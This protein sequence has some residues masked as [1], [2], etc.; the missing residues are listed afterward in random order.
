MTAIEQI[1]YLLFIKRLDEL[2]YNQQ[3]DAEFAGDAFTSRF[4]G[5]WL[6]SE[7]RDKPEME[8]D[9]KLK[10]QAFQDIQGDVYEYLLAE[11]AQAGKN[12]Q[13]RTPRH[14]IKLIAELV[15]PQLGHRIA[16]PACGTAGFLLGAYQYI[17]TQLALNKGVRDLQTDEDGF[18]RTSVSA[19]LTDKARNILNESLWGYDIDSTMV[20]EFLKSTFLEMFG[21]SVVGQK[22]YKFAL[23]DTFI[24]HLTSGGRGWAK[25]Y[26]ETGKRF[27]R[28]LD[29]QMNKIGNEDIVFVRPPKNQETE[30][31]RV[32]ENDVLLT[33]TGSKIGR[34][35]Y[36]P[37]NFEEAYISQHVSIIRTK[38][39]N[40][41]YLSYYLSMQNAGQRVIKKMQYGQ[42]KPGLNLT[43]IREFPILTPPINLQNKF[44]FIIKRVESL[45]TLYQ[46]NLSQLNNLY[47]ILSQKAFKG[48]LDLSRIPLPTITADNHITA[49]LPSIRGEAVTGEAML[50]SAGKA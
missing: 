30:R 7:Y 18:R 11:I 6:P 32:Q 14:I 43:Q 19:V 33:I 5:T 2:D 44:A 26:A 12:G 4:S 10:G 50:S 9:S 24:T 47:G 38:E 25:Y 46:Q 37:R 45:K 31:T 23:L 13:F 36:V 49:S 28:S 20:D 21:D 40:P 48:E 22:G 39:I 1:T 27:I 15:Q 8:K 34:V 41:I 17:V 29:V 3:G 35:A 42:A 16:D